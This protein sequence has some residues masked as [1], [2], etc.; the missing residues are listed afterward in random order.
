MRDA[1]IIGV[2]AIARTMNHEPIFDSGVWLTPIV[3]A[4]A[5][6]AVSLFLLVVR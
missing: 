2:R 6:I 1:Y 3:L 4:I 5:G